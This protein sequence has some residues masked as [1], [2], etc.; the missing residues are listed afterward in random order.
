MLKV[1]GSSGVMF[2]D[3]GSHSE[4]SVDAMHPVNETFVRSDNYTH[5]Y[6]HVKFKMSDFKIALGL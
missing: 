5:K 4:L 6:N 2:G 3:T 1:D